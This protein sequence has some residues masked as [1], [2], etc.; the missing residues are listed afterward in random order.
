MFEPNSYHVRA[1][2]PNRSLCQRQPIGPV[3]S[4]SRGRDCPCKHGEAIPSFVGRSRAERGI[5]GRSS[6]RTP[7]RGVAPASLLAASERPAR[8]PVLLHSWWDR[9][10]ACSSMTGILPVPPKKGLLSRVPRY[11]GWT[12]RNEA[13][14][15]GAPTPGISPEAIHRQ[16]PSSCRL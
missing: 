5:A 2:F 14:A 3:H 15:S 9:H 1:G 7:I 12:A 4:I 16:F 10:P 8:R 6:P 11:A 13:A